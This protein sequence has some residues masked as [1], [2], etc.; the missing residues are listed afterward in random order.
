MIME[1][2]VVDNQMEVVLTCSNYAEETA[3]VR[4]FLSSIISP[5][6]SLVIDL[7]QVDYIDTAGLGTLVYIQK[8][9]LLNGSGLKIKGLQ[10]NVKVLFEMTRMNKV[11]D[12]Q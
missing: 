5:R 3:E 6:K 7:S 4:A 9:A 1:S 8:C 10:G 11:F 2:N 12:I